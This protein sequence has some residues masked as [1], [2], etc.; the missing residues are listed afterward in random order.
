MV[1]WLNSEIPGKLTEL[2]GAKEAHVVVS[3]VEIERS[4]GGVPAL[5]NT[6]GVDWKGETV[7]EVEVVGATLMSV[8]HGKITS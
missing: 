3:N 6:V 8:R 4:V 5:S 7:N 1:S 2:L